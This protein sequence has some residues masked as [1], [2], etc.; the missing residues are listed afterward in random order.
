[1]ELSRDEWWVGGSVVCL[2]DRWAVCLVDQRA[3]M[4]AEWKAPS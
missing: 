1:L 4:M 3:E 2:V